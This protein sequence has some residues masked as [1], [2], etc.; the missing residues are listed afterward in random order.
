MKKYNPADKYES[1]LQK[2]DDVIKE[3]LGLGIIE[4][5]KTFIASEEVTCVPQREV[6][7]KDHVSKKLRL[8]FD[9][10]VKCGNNISLN[11]SYYNRPCL[12]PYLF[13]LFI[14]F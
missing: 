2:Y 3:H 9:C 13:D 10:S 4:K 6:I 7:R 5:A 14:K 1:L 12:I 8:V 11:E